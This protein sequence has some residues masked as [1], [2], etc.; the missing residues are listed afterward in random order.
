MET[1]TTQEYVTDAFGTTRLQNVTTQQG[2]GVT[3]SGFS[4]SDVNDAKGILS[5]I[6]NNSTVKEL[7]DLSPTLNDEELYAPIYY[8]KINESNRSSE[9]KE[10][11]ESIIKD[12][13]IKSSEPPVSYSVS[14]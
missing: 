4:S 10:L 8:Q 5:D 13:E 12:I 6:F 7:I 14:K 3:V 2:T 9:G 1:V 11:L